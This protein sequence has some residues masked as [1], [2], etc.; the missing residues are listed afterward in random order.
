MAFRP[1]SDADL[2][3]LLT[4]QGEYY[5]EDGYPFSLED[6]RVAAS[7]LVGEPSLG[8]AWIAE[9]NGELAGFL[10]V[11]YG[12][13]LEYNGKDAFVDELYV[14]P[15]FRGHGLGREGLGLAEWVCRGAGVRALHLEVERRRHDRT[16]QM[17][18]RAG[19]VEHDR[20][21]MTKRLDEPEPDAP[22]Q[23]A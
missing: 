16:R 11:T 12:W 15:R 7:T 14:R 13:S 3:A 2:E 20:Y 5:E 18:R 1:A 6:A 9:E 21:L 8:S 4:L 17:Y 23:E 22:K 10:I 19:F